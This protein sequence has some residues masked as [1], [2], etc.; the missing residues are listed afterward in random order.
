MTQRMNL[1]HASSQCLCKSELAL[2][3]LGGWLTGWGCGS[4]AAPSSGWGVAHQLLSPPAGGVAHL[5]L[6]PPA[7][8]TG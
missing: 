7:G 3:S 1:A 8:W 2:P 6:S 5:L 4:S